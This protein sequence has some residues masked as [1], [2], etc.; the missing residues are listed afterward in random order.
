MWFHF[1]QI[2]QDSI[3]TGWPRYRE[4]REF[5]HQFFQ[6]QGIFQISLKIKYI[7]Y[8]KLPF[9]PLMYPSFFLAWL[10]SPSFHK[11]SSCSC[12]SHTFM[13]GSW[14]DKW[15]LF[16]DERG[17]RMALMGWWRP[18]QIKKIFSLEK[19][20]E[21]LQRQGKDREFHFN[22]SVATLSM[23]HHCAK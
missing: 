20:R 3:S 8:S 17:E 6:T 23:H 1:H 14:S 2:V 9:H 18:L 21:K 10:C 5:G 13:S 16:C 22:L 11:L 12:C 7:F 19:H 15:N 4:N